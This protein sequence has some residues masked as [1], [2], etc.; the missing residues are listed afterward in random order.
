MTLVLNSSFILAVIIISDVKSITSFHP[1]N[2][3][4]INPSVFMVNFTLID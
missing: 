2:T 1:L 4:G 3:V